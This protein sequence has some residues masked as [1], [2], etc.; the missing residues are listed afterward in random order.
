[1][2]SPGLASPPVTASG[3]R[4]GLDRRLRPAT[5][6]GLLSW[7]SHQLRLETPELGHSAS[8][9]DDGGSPDMKA[10]AKAYLALTTRVQVDDRPD[11]WRA[12]ACRLDK[13]GFYVTPLRCALEGL[14]A[15]RR[16]LLRDA[17]ANELFALDMATIHGIPTWAAGD[18]LFRSL[19]L[20]WD[21]YLD[22]PL[23]RRSWIELSDSQRAAVQAGERQ[24][25]VA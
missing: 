9:T 24:Q 12:I 5:L 17:L 14:P 6:R 4:S 23:P 19:R 18:V 15:E 22:R 13:D 20:L 1:M 7:A 3:S 21:R 25:A 10:A 2:T 16:A 8:L 11:S